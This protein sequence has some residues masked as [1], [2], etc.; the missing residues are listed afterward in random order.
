MWG[1]NPATFFLLI[2]FVEKKFS[3]AVQFSEH[4]SEKKKTLNNYT[5]R[6]ESV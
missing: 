1:C 3:T 5:L 4:F 2:S 6:Q